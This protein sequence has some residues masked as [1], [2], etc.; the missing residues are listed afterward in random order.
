MALE[1]FQQETCIFHNPDVT[2][3]YKDM[4]DHTHFPIFP[5]IVALWF[6]FFS[7]FPLAKINQISKIICEF[8]HDH[9]RSHLN[10]VLNIG[11]SV[12][13][14]L[15]QVSC[16]NQLLPLSTQDGHS[17]LRPGRLLRAH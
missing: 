14:I 4:H 2:D 11:I 7:P 16:Q 9:R 13:Y 3:T 8:Y 6:F 12:S 15:T 1:Q 5:E 10:T 17:I